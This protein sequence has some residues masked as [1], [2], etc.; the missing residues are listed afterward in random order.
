MYGGHTR[1][2]VSTRSWEMLADT[3]NLQ[4]TVKSLTPA[5]FSPCTSAA[6]LLIYAGA[7]RPESVLKGFQRHQ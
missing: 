6:S 1:S 4:S 2:L 5:A 3:R 7:G